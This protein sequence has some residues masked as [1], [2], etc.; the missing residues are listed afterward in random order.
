[1]AHLC[2]GCVLATEGS[3]GLGLEVLRLVSQGVG[4]V[5]KGVERSAAAGGT[6]RGCLV[7]VL[8]FQP[9]SRP[10]PGWSGCRSELICFSEEGLV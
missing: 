10:T 2:R 7:P 1:M 8:G 6:G 3:P 9:R 4:K 5:W